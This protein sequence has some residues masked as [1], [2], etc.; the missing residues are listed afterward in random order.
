MKSPCVIHCAA[1]VIVSSSDIMVPLSVIGRRVMNGAEEIPV[2]LHL[3]VIVYPDESH[4]LV[5]KF[6]D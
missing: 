2:I 1:L 3:E 5:D 4:V 6:V